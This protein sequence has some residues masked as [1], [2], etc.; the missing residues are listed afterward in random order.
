MFNN[1]T[2][3]K[4]LTLIS[5]A[6]MIAVNAAANILPINGITAGG[7]SD[8]YPN[9]FAPAGVTFSIWGLI[10]LLLA[11]Y[12]V[13]QFFP[14]PKK[15]QLLIN[16]INRYFIFSSIINSTWI[17]FWHYQIISVTVFLMLLL[18]YSLIK[19]SNL[20]NKEELFLKDKLFIKIPFGL[21][22]GWITIATIANIT[23]F[24]V[25]LGWSDFIFSDQVWMI[26]VLLVGLVITSWK[27]I[28]SK[29]L[30]YGLV[31]IWAYYGIYLKHTSALE[32]NNE[33]PIIILV[34]MICILI[35]LM[36]N[37]YL[38]IKKTIV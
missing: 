5:F 1:K 35:F 27:T 19:I 30:A 15:T 22:F 38:V 29:N 21:Y 23:T 10:Y 12:V 37:F 9:L 2:F 11:I 13:Y 4:I 17:F 3:L 16:Q 34:T 25:S 24:F 33:Y 31:P 18:L 6:L 8:S 36:V 26:I 14:K 28:T 20:S 7:V 32:F